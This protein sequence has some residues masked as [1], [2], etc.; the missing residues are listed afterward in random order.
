M[1][2][3]IV[4]ACKLHPNTT[5]RAIVVEM[6]ARNSDVQ[7]VLKYNREEIILNAHVHDPRPIPEAFVSAESTRLKRL[8]YRW[9]LEFSKGNSGVDL[10]ALGYCLVLDDRPPQCCLS[11][12]RYS[13]RNKISFCS[14]SVRF[15]LNVSRR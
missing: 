9:G 11:S 4:E 2:L 6:Y 7:R 15:M 1:A 10:E 12:F 3:T 8:I 14:P 13:Q 5:I